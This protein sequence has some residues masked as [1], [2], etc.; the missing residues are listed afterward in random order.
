VGGSGVYNFK[1]VKQDDN[2]GVQAQHKNVELAPGLENRR[3]F[4]LGLV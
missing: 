3:L 2:E 1:N 4:M